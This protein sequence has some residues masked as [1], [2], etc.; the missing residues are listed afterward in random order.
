M[1]P[2][3]YIPSLISLS[4][5]AMF[6]TNEAWRKAAI[7]VKSEADMRKL[8]WSADHLAELVEFVPKPPEEPPPF[9]RI[10]LDE[11][12]ATSYDARLRGPR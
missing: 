1:E 2:N 7:K 12:H 6:G 11:R 5:A 3:A 9:A 8:G 10:E 4:Q